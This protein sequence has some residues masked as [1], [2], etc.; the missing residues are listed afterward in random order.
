M[1]DLEITSRVSIPEREIEM[2][3]TRS[4]GPGGQNV[5]KVSTA[6]HLRFDVRGSSLPAAWKARLLALPDQRITADGV[7]VIKAQD[8]RSLEMNRAAALERLRALVGSISRPPRPRIPTRPTAAA[9]KRRVDEK[10]RKGRIK[11]LRGR[12]RDE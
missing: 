5:N 4:G 3:A 7:V 6:V 10:A 2:S 9:K 1:A 11:A 12:I 8:H